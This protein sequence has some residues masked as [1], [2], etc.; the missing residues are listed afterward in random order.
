MIHDSCVFNESFCV[1][2]AIDMIEV[3]SK[4]TLV[5]VIKFDLVNTLLPH[6]TKM[7]RGGH[8]YKPPLLLHVAK[9]RPG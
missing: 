5:I 1:P 8:K 9:M 4:K 6:V 3:T 7:Q 2:R